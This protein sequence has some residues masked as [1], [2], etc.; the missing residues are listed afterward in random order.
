M[1]DKKTEDFEN[2]IS[3]NGLKIIE[4]F[5]AR[6]LTVLECILKGKKIRK[7]AKPSAFYFIWSKFSK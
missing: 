7:Y 4:A 1:S 3:D 2:L 6:P 5:K